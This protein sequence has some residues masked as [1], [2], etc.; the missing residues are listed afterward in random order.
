MFSQLKADLIGRDV[1]FADSFIWLPSPL[2]I[3][4][5][6][7]AP[8]WIAAKGAQ[9]LRPN[10]IKIQLGDRA[11]VEHVHAQLRP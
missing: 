3:E 7:E 2:L 1:V 8:L 6:F 5:F 4:C 9:R 11:G 10:G